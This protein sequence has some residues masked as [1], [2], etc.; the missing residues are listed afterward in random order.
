MQT[1]TILSVASVSVGANVPSAPNGAGG[2]GAQAWHV[3]YAYQKD[4]G[5]T[6]QADVWVGSFSGLGVGTIPQ[7]PLWTS[8]TATIGPF[9]P[10]GTTNPVSLP[11]P[12]AVQ[13]ALFGPVVYV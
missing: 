4:D 3:Q 2:G 9:T 12:L 11:C 7:S 8:P 13:K 1:G 10:T 5:S 6:G